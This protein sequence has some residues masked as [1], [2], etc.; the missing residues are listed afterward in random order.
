MSITG[1]FIYWSQTETNDESLTAE[2][3]MCQATAWG[4]VGFA[5]QGMRW[6]VVR[7]LQ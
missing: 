6:M 1:L 4:R 3:V 2:A 7:T 5:N